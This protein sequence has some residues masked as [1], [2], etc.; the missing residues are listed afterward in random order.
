MTYYPDT[1]N[2]YPNATSVTVTTGPVTRAVTMAEAVQQ[3][4]LDDI[5]EQNS[6][7]ELLIDGVIGDIEATYDLALITQTITEKFPRFPSGAGA[8]ILRK[9]PLLAITSISYID[10]DGATQTWSSSEYTS[11]TYNGRGFVVSKVDY[12]YP[13]DLVI[14]PDAVTVVYTAGFG[15]TPDTVPRPIKI[16][17]LLMIADLHANP[18]NPVRN[19]PQLSERFLQRYYP[20]GK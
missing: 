4:R 13:T 20:W 2:L 19:L 17:A 1:A 11:G 16:G 8:L 5:D 18:T 7:V 3:L 15:A 9:A 12:E 10:S 14:R 6:Y